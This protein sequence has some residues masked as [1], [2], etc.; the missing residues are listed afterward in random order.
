MSARAASRLAW[1]LCAV[2]LALVV[3][4][5]VALAPDRDVPGCEGD[6]G[7]RGRRS[8]SALALLAFPVVGALIVSRDRTTRSAGSSARSACPF[9]L[10]RAR[11]RLGRRTRCSRSPARCPAGEVA[12]WLASWL[13]VPPLFAVPPLL[14]LL[15]PTAA[16]PSPR[17]RPVVWVVGVAVCA[18]ARRQRAHARPAR[19]SRR[20]GGS[21]TRSASTAPDGRSRSSARV[22]FISALLRD[23][24]RRGRDR[25]RASGAA[26]GDERLS[27]SSGSRPRAR[28]SRSPASSTLVAVLA[29]CRATRPARC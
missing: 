3:P 14:F 28:C 21:T 11:A 18:A 25:G 9:G 29:G 24:A 2:A 12:A 26:R 19:P 27:S 8:A 5:S 23:P 22:G 1:L 4:A 16:R 6:V 17:W 15:F 20:S 7:V 10:V 13:F